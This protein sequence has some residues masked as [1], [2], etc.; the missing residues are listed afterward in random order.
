MSRS[1][2][3]HR[4]HERDG[5]WGS[6]GGLAATDRPLAPNNLSGPE[7]DIGREYRNAFLR[8]HSWLRAELDAIRS[9]AARA[10]AGQVDDNAAAVLIG[11]FALVRHRWNLAEFCAGYC[12]A[13]DSHHRREDREM[14]PA[15]LDA[16]PDL[17]DVVDRLRAEHLVIAHAV[18]RL[19]LAL[20]ALTESPKASGDVT[21]AAADLSSLLLSHLAYEEDQ[22]HDG[23]GRLTGAHL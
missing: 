19:Q 15:V 10:T 21:A 18:E 11:D 8:S 12:G 1:Q 20:T 4:I 6:A 3:A 16:V 17:A 22:L 2:D 7:T 5:Q 9:V 23:L 14:F 13:L